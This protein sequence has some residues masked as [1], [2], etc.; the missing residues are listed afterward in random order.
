M[1]IRYQTKIQEQQR[2]RPNWLSVT[3]KKVLGVGN[4]AV[5][6]SEGRVEKAIKKKLG[7]D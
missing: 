4:R 2:R 3:N 5:T 1:T 7:A 6:I